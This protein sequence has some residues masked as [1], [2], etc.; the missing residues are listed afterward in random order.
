MC[1][2]RLVS[3]NERLRNATVQKCPMTMVGHQHV[4]AQRSQPWCGFCNRV[5]A[6]EFRDKDERR[7]RCELIVV[8]WG[9]GASP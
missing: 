5:A 2:R 4:K 9:L 3:E 6:I 7:S 8:D 1:P